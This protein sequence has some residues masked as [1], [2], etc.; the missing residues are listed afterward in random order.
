[1]SGIEDIK[2]KLKAF[3]KRYYIRQLFV[4]SLIFLIASSGLFLVVNGLEYQLWLGTTARSILFF[5]SLLLVLILFAWLVAKPISLLLKLRQGIDDEEAAKEIAKSFPAIEDRLINTLQLHRLSSHENALLSAAIDKKASTF[6]NISF[7]KAVDFSAGKRYGTILGVIVLGLILVSFINPSIFKDS[8]KRIVNFNQEFTPNAPFKFIITS[9]LQAF[10]GEDFTLKISVDGAA[11]P[12]NASIRT[13]DGQ[14]LRL[15]KIGSSS[16][17]YVFEKIQKSISFQLEGQGFYSNQYSLAVND[18]P[19]LIAMN[20]SIQSPAYTGGE[21]KVITNSGDITVLEGSS[22]AWEI[23]TLA[24]DSINF[25]IGGQNVANNRLSENLFRIDQRLFSSNPYAVQLYNPFGSNSSELN[26]GISVI[27][28]EKPQ[29]STEYFPD[30]LAFQFVTLAGNIIDDH[31]FTSL[32]LNYKKEGEVLKSIPLELSPSIKKQGFYANWNVDSLKLEAGER[33]EFF[34]RV[35]DNDQVNGSKSSKSRTFIMQIPSED[36]IEEIIDK[37]S[38]TVENQ[39]DKSKKEAESIN[40]RLKDIEEKLKTEQQFD[41]QEKKQLNDIIK[42]RE[43]LENQI[44][45]LQKQ[46]E[47]LQRSSDQF[48]KRSE[49]NKQQNEK[50]QSLLDELLD[51]KTRELYEK[52]KELLKDENASSEQ[53][54]QEVQ[55]IQRNEKNLEKELDRALE[56]FKR[57]KMESVLE[58][59]L[60]KLDTLSKRQSEL[61]EQNSEDAD[62][63]QIEEEQK[64]IQEEFEEFREKMDEV[65]QLNQELERPEALQDFELEERQIS[66]ELREIEEQL[67]EQNQQADSTSQQQKDQESEQSENSGEKRKGEEEQQQNPEEN[68]SSQQEQSQQQNKQNSQKQT[69]Q[70][71]KNASQR[72][73]QLSKQLSNMQS[74]MQMEMMQANLDQLRDILDNLVKLSFNQE[75]LLSE[76]RTVNQSDPRFLELSQSQLKLKDDAK[77]IQDSLLSLAEKVVQISSYITREVGSIN[78]NIDG[79]L[80]HLKDRNRGRALS[81]Q[82]FAMT[83]INNLALLLDDTMQQMQMAMSEAMGNPQ[84]GQQQ[85]N[86]LP[87]LQQMQQQLGQQMNELKGSGKQGRELSEELARLAAEQEIIRRQLEMI[88]QAEDGQPGGGS[89]GGDDLQKAIDQMEQNE[90][91]LVNKR[92]TQQ[93][94]NRQKSIETRL[95]EA[96]KA[97]REQEME[98]EREAESPSIFSRE[99]PPQFEEYLKMKQK[100]IELLKTI[101]AELNPFYKKEVNDYFRRISS[102]KEDDR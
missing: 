26:Y 22:V 58:Q 28:D 20:I 83:S 34:V 12:E 98:E 60:Q 91:D 6:Q 53:V 64:E 90:V 43:D 2:R 18:R 72:M 97:Q 56:L 16:F 57:L 96:D 21:R 59:N 8:T 69:Q 79:A 19:D 101:P 82:Q 95:L 15:Q 48:N 55:D 85:Q 77:V 49:Q 87:D 78:E 73:K 39:I 35:S 7:I 13:E 65:E 71:Q 5:S 76:M 3:K 42:D 27:K 24:A 9:S 50:L 29:I 23:S 63:N 86:G 102:E 32:S 62:Q 81:S 41:W 74:G 10:R 25:L 84:Q 40:E 36:E 30:T 75:D 70:K 67:K 94:L 33:L 52:L 45:E 80:K 92:L 31:G 11:I 99:I 17:Q 66:K 1:M 61:A 38:Q 51:E 88:K 54:R 93:L 44:K 14:R 68:E 100:E 46:H 89:G 37:K 47:E 4:G